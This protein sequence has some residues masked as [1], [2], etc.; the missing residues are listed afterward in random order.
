[1]TLTG[2]ESVP[3]EVSERLLKMAPRFVS[4]L[5]F[6]GTATSARIEEEWHISGTEVRAIVHHLRSQGDPE[7][8]RIAADQKGYRWANDY[9][10]MRTTLESMEQRERSIRRARF[11]ILRSFGKDTSQQEL[12][13]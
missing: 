4:W 8:S 12:S 13:L 2:F 3:N 10:A 1:M 5:K 6:I 11:G 7:M 9:E